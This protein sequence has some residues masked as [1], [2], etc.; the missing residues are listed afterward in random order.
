GAETWRGIE[1]RYSPRGVEAD[2]LLLDL[3][4]RAPRASDLLLVSSD[5]SVADRARSFGASVAR[6]DELIGK[7][8]TAGA[9]PARTGPAAF[10][11][12]VKGMIRHAPR[13][14]SAAR[15]RQ[16]LQLW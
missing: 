5:K 4:E 13:A 3:V 2:D 1:V 6:A 9:G 16:R 8:R 7:L 14:R 10:E 11:E 15:T 12:H